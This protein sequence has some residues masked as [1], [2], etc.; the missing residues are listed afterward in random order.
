MH[1]LLIAIVE[2]ELTLTELEQGILENLPQLPRFT[3]KVTPHRLRLRRPSWQEDPLFNLDR[4]LFDVQLTPS[5][6]DDD[7]LSLAAKIFAV[8]LDRGKPLWELHLVH[9]LTENRSA[10]MVKM[11]RCLGDAATALELLT[12]RHDDLAPS[13]HEFADATRSGTTTA[14][15]LHCAYS[16][17]EVR[18]IAATC[19]AESTDALLSVLA[20]GVRRYLKLHQTPTEGKSLRLLLSVPIDVPLDLKDPIECLQYVTENSKMGKTPGR[21]R[22]SFPDSISVT[23][24]SLPQSPL[25]LFGRR[26]AAIYPFPN[27]A[28]GVSCALF[29]YDEKVNLLLTIDT[30][31]I[32]DAQR[33]QWCFDQSFAQLRDATGVT[34]QETFNVRLQQA[35]E[36]ERYE[37]LSEYVREQVAIVL[38]WEGEQPPDPQQ[39]FFDLGLNSLSTMRLAG[40]LQSGFG[41]QLP[42]TL[43]F[44]TPNLEALTNYLAK[45]VLGWNN[46]ASEPVETSQKQTDTPQQLLGKIQDLSDDEV[47]RLLAKT[48]EPGR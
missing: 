33:L 1:H 39:G 15:L 31:A 38:N 8:A 30:Q 18:A 34:V 5:G 20:R 9:N 2:G 6:A 37:L 22:Y 16:L 17:P 28:N 44:E 21:S 10:V 41:T 36:T 12:G 4:H 35:P 32:P 46:P 23:T 7:L 47:D 13:S 25:Y 40:R 3:Q 26:A 11:H 45:E 48:S 14:T 29:E 27:I 43:I 42:A 24:V 19:G